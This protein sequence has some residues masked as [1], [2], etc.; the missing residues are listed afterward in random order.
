MVT[1]SLISILSCQKIVKHK[2]RSWPLNA[3]NIRAQAGAPDIGNAN[4]KAK[5]SQMGGAP[6][7][8]PC[9]I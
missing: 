7:A 6:K 1:S 4:I 3:V 5:S 9:F 2:Q 8:R